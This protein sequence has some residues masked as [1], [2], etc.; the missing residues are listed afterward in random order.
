MPAL[1]SK[2]V[3]RNNGQNIEDIFSSH[4]PS[5][6]GAVT[7]S[8]KNTSVSKSATATHKNSGEVLALTP[9]SAE[10]CLMEGIDPKDLYE[11]T[12]ESFGEGS[13]LDPAIVRMVSLFFLSL[14]LSLYYE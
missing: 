12:L 4:S 8:S 11:R 9:R 1:K 13:N 7:L 3:V 10:A 14:S 2:L 5:S 6:S